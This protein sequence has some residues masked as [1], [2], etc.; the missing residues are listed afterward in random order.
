LTG[1]LKGKGIRE[2][3]ESGLGQENKQW[4]ANRRKWF[5]KVSS[6]IEQLAAS[7]VGQLVAIFWKKVRVIQDVF[8]SSIDTHDNFENEK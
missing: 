2:L 6:R 3:T 4:I 7:V 8:Y 5:M 1:Q